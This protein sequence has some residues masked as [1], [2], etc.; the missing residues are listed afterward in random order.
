MILS[1]VSVKRTL[2]LS[3]QAVIL[4]WQTSLSSEFRVVSTLRLFLRSQMGLVEFA[5]YLACGKIHMLKQVEILFLSIT[6]GR[7]MRVISL[8]S[9]FNILLIILT[10]SENI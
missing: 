4:Q 8:L 6:S 7:E 3:S 9:F 5:K 2:K 1:K 10:F